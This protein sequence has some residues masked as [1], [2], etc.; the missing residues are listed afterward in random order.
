M[1]EKKK[2]GLDLPQ[3]IVIAVVGA[4]FILTAGMIV[5]WGPADASTQVMEWVSLGIGSVGLLFAAMRSKGLFVNKGASSMN[6][7]GE[8]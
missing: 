8:S 3:A 7:E 5:V 4:A 2:K 1:T 6:D